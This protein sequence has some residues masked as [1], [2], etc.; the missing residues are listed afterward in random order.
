V[1]AIV[2]VVAFGQALPPLWG[3]VISVGWGLLL[4]GISLWVSSSLLRRRM[5]EVLGWVHV[6]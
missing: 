6:S 2:L 1:S 5:P 4:Y 3:A